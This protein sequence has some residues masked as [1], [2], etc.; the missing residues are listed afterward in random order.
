MPYRLLRLVEPLS[1]NISTRNLQHRKLLEIYKKRT[2]TLERVH[3]G[4]RKPGV[5]GGNNKAEMK[6]CIGG[7]GS[8][9]L[10]RML[11]LLSPGPGGEGVRG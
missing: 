9:C 4:A 11:P 1:S 7:E 10:T 8:I 3:G 6:A 5:E 2:P